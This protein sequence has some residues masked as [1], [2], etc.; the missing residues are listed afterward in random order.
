MYVP[1]GPLLDWSDDALVHEVLT[2]L[3]HFA[4]TKGAIF[5]KIDPDLARWLWHSRQRT[6]QDSPSGGSVQ[7]KLKNLGWRFQMSKSISQYGHDR[8]TT[9]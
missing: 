6:R 1:R 7:E 2:D 5:I 3:Q 9:E 8:F 4:K